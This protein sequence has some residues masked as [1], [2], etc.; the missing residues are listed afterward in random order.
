VRILII[1]CCLAVGNCQYL[2]DDS[3]VSRL[4]KL[5]E[6]QVSLARQWAKDPR[7][8]YRAWAA[9]ILRRSGGASM[10]IDLLPMLG[11]PAELR[12]LSPFKDV[13]EPLSDEDR[14]R[15]TILH[16]LIER[17]SPVPEDVGLALFARY[18]AEAVVALYRSR[19]PSTAASVY[20]REHAQSDAIWLAAAQCLA[21]QPGGPANLL[22][23]M[24]KIQLTVWDRKKEWMPRGVIGGI[25]GIMLGGLSDWP[26]YCAYFLYVG[27]RAPISSTLLVTGKYPVYYLEIPNAASV[28]RPTSG[29]LPDR[30]DYVFEILAERIARITGN[31]VAPVT[32]S[33]RI[34]WRTAGQ[35][36]SEIQAFA[37]E[38]QQ[39]YD[40]MLATLLSQGLLNAAEREQ[41]GPTL[42]FEVVDDRLDRSEPIPNAGIGDHLLRAN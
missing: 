37:A 13:Y 36:R 21:G 40:A 32:R 15:L 7:P 6:S 16:A 31:V 30:G 33:V 11:D 34:Q 24:Q 17:Q 4:S 9:E 23:D 26:P 19:C 42:D 5:Q 22:Q 25:P 41:C 29:N 2:P 10:R 20:I 38:Q 35:Y 18:P 12:K 1:L 39:R 3:P 27:E 28:G 14:L 8:L